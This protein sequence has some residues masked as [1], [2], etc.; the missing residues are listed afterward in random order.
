[1]AFGL[2]GSGFSGYLYYAVPFIF[3]FALVFGVLTLS[4]IFEKQKNV[5]AL[6]AAAI[7]LF[8]TM[9]SQ[10]ITL[11]YEWLPYLS[12]L[13]LVIFVLVI[14]KNIFFDK[15]KEKISGP[16]IVAVLI[17]FL[18]FLAVYPE[19]PL[20]HGNMISEGDVL[21]IIGIVFV[22][23]L[24]FLGFKLNIPE[25]TKSSKDNTSD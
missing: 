21:M 9:S 24:I 23:I 20:P 22:A 19:I 14:L 15:S 4:K 1:M 6:L 17:I 3:T 16:M 12:I 7:A 10:Y 25:T 2:F 18:V 5:N 13:F 8:A 11:L